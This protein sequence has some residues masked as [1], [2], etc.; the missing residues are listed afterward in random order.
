MSTDPL[1]MKQGGQYYW[2]HNDH[3]GTPQMMTT[4]SG[5]VV[6]SAKYTSFGKATVDP[7]STIVNPLRFPGQ[8]EDVE[9]GLHYNLHRYYSANLG[10]YLKNDPIGLDGGINLYVYVSSEPVNWFDP[11]GLEEKRPS[12]PKIRRDWEKFYDEKWPKDPDT[13]WNQD[14]HHKKPH[15]EG[16]PHT[17][18][19]IEPKTR[20]DHINHHKEKGDYKKWGKKRKKP[21]IPVIKPNPPGAPK[22]PIIFFID[23]RMLCANAPNDPFCRWYC[24]MIGGC[25]CPE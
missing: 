7:S 13:G 22:G 8:Y 9:T 5:A 25:P 10:R 1:F 6:W 11:Y 20:K 14:A 2:Y 24:P 21:R 15:S 3:L 4:T 19:N 18:E 23:F 12:T 16:G 17:P